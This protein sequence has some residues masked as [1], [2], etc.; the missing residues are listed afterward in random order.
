MPAPP[1]ISYDLF[2]ALH[3]YV[4][5]KHP[6]KIKRVFAFGS[7]F[8]FVFLFVFVT[9]SSGCGNCGKLEAF[10]AQSFP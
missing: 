8:C 7:V 10:F 5:V 1:V 3:C 2:D 9:S 4:N 6:E